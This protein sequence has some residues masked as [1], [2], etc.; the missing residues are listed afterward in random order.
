M[1]NLQSYTTWD[2][3]RVLGFPLHWLGRKR[4]VIL[5][6]EQSILVWS[7]QA[8]RFHLKCW[9]I[10]DGEQM[11]WSKESKQHQGR[12]RLH[13]KFK[14]IYTQQMKRMLRSKPKLK[15]NLC[16]VKVSNVECHFYFLCLSVWRN[17]CKWPPSGQLI[18]LATVNKKRTVTIWS[19]VPGLV[20][21]PVF[22]MIS[23]CCV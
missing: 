4:K 17:K 15:Y 13:V 12:V 2:K 1:V 8:G 11:P 18:H 22:R 5:D 19:W 9:F 20:V 6:T 23:L 3:N 14:F 10:S 21:C 7:Q 16:L